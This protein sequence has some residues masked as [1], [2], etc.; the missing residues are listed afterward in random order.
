MT[1]IAC[2]AH[3]Q[4]VLGE[5]PRWHPVEEALYWIDAFK[6]AV[7]RL[8]PASG[9]VESF[10]PPEKLGSF[11]PCAGGSLLIAGR[12]GLA[13][14]DPPSGRLERIAD[15]E[16]GGAV[17]ILND[18]RCDKRGRFWV[19]SMSKTMARASGRLYRL[20]RGR[21]DAVAEDIWVSNGVCFSPDDSRMYFADS[22]LKTIFVYDFDLAAGTLGARRVFA[23]MGEKPGVPDGSCVDVDGFVWNAAFDAGLIVRYAP[24]GRVDRTVALPVSRPTAC[25]FGGANL[26]TLYVTTAR[27]RL[28]PD[29][30]AAET[31]A[32]GL[33]ALDV[34]ARG[35][36]EPM[37]AI[38]CQRSDVGG[39]S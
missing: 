30:L 26:A 5:V 15:P 37:Y 22:H 32:G 12:N 19:G 33:L 20:E 24:D 14:Y 7:H 27:F 29:R 2:V 35:L 39:Q 1:V 10:T 11:A 25:T 3:T 36:P 18:G 9:K 34:G 13:F 38:G 21:L 6:P 31:Y 16:A 8:D 17:N 28:P 4:D 23:A